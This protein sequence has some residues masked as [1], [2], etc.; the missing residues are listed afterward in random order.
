MEKGSFQK[1]P[2]SRDSR[3]S[4][5]EVLEVLE[6]PQ[7][8]EKKGESDRF[9]ETPEKFFRDSRDSSSEKTPFGNDPLLSGPDFEG[10]NTSLRRVRLPSRAPYTCSG[11]P[12]TWPVKHENEPFST[13]TH[14]AAMQGTP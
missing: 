13:L 14:A 4:R 1:S 9:L 11:S 3:E 5:L 8:L 10:R 6:T 12:G 7:T 2:L